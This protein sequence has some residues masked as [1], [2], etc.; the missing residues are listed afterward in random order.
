[1]KTNKTQAVLLMYK[2]LLETGKLR[3]DDVMMK[4]EMT[5]LSFRRYI[6]ELRC[7]FMNF[8]EPLEIIYVKA[9]NCYY[10]KK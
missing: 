9:E 8:D 10:L 4:V 2:I 1:M 6:S 3:K 7:F 5:D